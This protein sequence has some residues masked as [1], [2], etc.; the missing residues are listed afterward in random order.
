MVYLSKREL[1]SS[2]YPVHDFIREQLMH[3]FVMPDADIQ[4]PHLITILALK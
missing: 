4:G 2:E 1:H 3:L